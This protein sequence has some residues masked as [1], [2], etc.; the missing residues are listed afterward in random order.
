MPAP[1]KQRKIAIVGSRSVGK[2]SLTVRFV[3]G[4]FVESYYPTIE[5]TFSKVIKYK[6]QEYA[7]EIIDT[8]GQDEYSI[9]NSK[10]FIG[11]HGYMLVY[12]VASTQSF[13]MVQVI[14]DKILN[15]LGTEWVPIVVVGNKSDLRPEQ[16]QV[17]AEEGK[18]LADKFQCAY[19][20]ASARYDENSTPTFEMLDIADFIVEK[21][22]NPQKIKESQRRRYAP[23]EAVDEVIA[24]YEDHRK[25]Q[26][27]AT[28]I[29]SKINEIQKQI[30]IKKKAKENADDLMKQKVDLEK[31]K[32]ALIDSA[33]EKDLAL[34]KKIGTIGNIVHD[35][36]PVNDNEDFNTLQRTWAPEG[37]KVEK[38]DVLSHHEVLTRLDGY[39]PERGV[40]VTAQLEQ[41]DEELY[42][43]VD[44]DAQNDKYLIATSEQPI[45]AFHADE[46]LVTKDL[47]IRYAGFSSCYRREAGSHGRDAWGIFR[48]HQF[49]KIEQF[50]LA[51]PEKSWDEFDRMISISEEFYKSLGVPY[52]VVA[53]VS[54]ALNNA[55][56]KKYDLEAWFPF[57]GEYKELVSC[58][59]CTDYQSRAL[60]I[61]YGAKLQTEIRKKYVHALN[62]TLCA[63]ERALCCLLENFQTE[64]GFN[65]PEPL[66]K[67]LPGAPEFIPFTKELPK[68]STSQKVKG[69]VDK[70]PKPKVAPATG[71]VTQA[72]ETL[73]DLKV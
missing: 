50:V 73:K 19:T 22:G 44:G 8:A 1:P 32:K 31:E 7:T 57:Q 17:T 13:E 65:V 45:S 3:D 53:I 29:N 20:E 43:V 54:G 59:N 2:S 39:D 52:R 30:G 49:E 28:Q 69:K 48:V 58:S 46:W 35:S 55:A 12:S 6:G 24:L 56:S 26:Y 47:P 70:A 68:D 41:F 64:D 37:V 72:A 25:T 62:S 40:K 9:L 11:I 27:A 60:E 67:Y 42:K 51:E 36:V 21:G 66:R 61:R 38:R 15:H 71:E 34:K 5:N 18:K 4:H 14:R 10:H 16:R 63:T 23:E 33:A